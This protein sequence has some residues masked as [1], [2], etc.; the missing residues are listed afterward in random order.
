[1]RYV[2]ILAMIGLVG[3]IAWLVADPGFEPA[4]AVVAAISALV[5]AFVVE[6][7]LRRQPQQHQSVSKSST[8]IQAG[9]DVNIGNLSSDKHDK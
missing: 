3:A 7:R 6:R 4:L 5:S 1:M 8:G 2:K 9:G